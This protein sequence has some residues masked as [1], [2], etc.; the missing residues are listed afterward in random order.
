MINNKFHR[1]STVFLLRNQKFVFFFLKIYLY[2]EFPHEKNKF[3]QET[4]MGFVQET[5]NFVREIRALF[6]KKT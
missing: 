3:Y 6:L 4:I 1:E 5:L 2:T